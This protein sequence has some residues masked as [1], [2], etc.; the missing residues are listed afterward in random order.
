M[1][2][3]PG[4]WHQNICRGFIGLTNLDI[5]F[6]LLQAF[7]CLAVPEGIISLWVV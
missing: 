1:V 5:R 6:H 7:P 2:D 4:S 3:I